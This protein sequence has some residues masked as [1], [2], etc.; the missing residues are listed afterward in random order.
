MAIEAM[1]LSAMLHAPVAIETW[2]PPGSDP[3]QDPAGYRRVYTDR[4][5]D[6]ALVAA[7]LD[8]MFGP[9]PG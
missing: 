9:M 7:G 3:R 8:A 5:Q 4:H 1:Q 2:E 6:P